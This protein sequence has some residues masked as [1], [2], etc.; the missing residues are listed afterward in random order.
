MKTMFFYGTLCHLP[1]LDIVLGPERAATQ[2]TP[3]RLPGHAA[4]W[5]AGAGYPMIRAEPGAAAPGLL[6]SGLSDDAVAR[7]DFYE[8][9]HAYTLH[10]VPVDTD[11]GRQMALVYFPDTPPEP[12]APWVLADWQAR[13]GA[14]TILAAAEAMQGYG[15]QSPAELVRRFPSIRARAAARLNARHSPPTTLRRRA[16]PGDVRVL[17]RRQP[18]AHFFSVEEY[19]LTHET[20]QGG[21]SAPLD[22]AVF[23]STDAVT[24][25]PYDAKRDRVLLIEQFRMGP[26]ARGDAQCWSLEAIAGRVEPGEP[27]EET[28][29][30][31]ALEEAGLEIGKMLP[32]AGYYSSPGAKSEYLY[33]FVALTD[34][35][36]TAAGLGG[37]L[38]E[39]ED[40]RA[41]VVSY[42][43]L[44]AL[45]DSGELENAPLLVSVLWLARHRERLRADA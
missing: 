25:L 4:Y 22:R 39:G 33:S 15:H 19:D 38:A 44:M 7:L 40:I 31:E 27:A 12:G 20:F 43:R 42:D 18:Y 13:W 30:R 14:V 26:F 28:G 16:E 3:A 6:V 23:I 1:L 17:D 9:G 10:P 35:P 21:H 41:H 36:D 11:A 2:V 34:L 45:L 8:G 29:R 32:V 5:V 24:V 37:L